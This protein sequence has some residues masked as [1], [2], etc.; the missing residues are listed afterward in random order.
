MHSRC[1]VVP[2]IRTA[3]HSSAAPSPS[4]R[5]ARGETWLGCAFVSRDFHPL[6]TTSSP[7]A[8]NSDMCHQTNGLVRSI[9]LI[10]TPGARNVSPAPR[11]LRPGD[12]GRQRIT[13]GLQRS[14]NGQTAGYSAGIPFGFTG[15]YGHLFQT[16]LLKLLT[17]LRLRCVFIEVRHCRTALPHKRTALSPESFVVT[18]GAGTW[19]RD[20]KRRPP[21]RPTS[22]RRR[23]GA[24]QGMPGARPRSGAPARRFSGERQWGFHRFADRQD[25]ALLQS[26]AQAGV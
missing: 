2:P 7:G 17:L 15:N 19:C 5:T 3:A 18:R 24:Y 8:P 12:G 9:L 26:S 11:W 22:S 1:S 6:P 14:A 13:E 25:V 21:V 10:R 4:R 16:I 23:P 20:R